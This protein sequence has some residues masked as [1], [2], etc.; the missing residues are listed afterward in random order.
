MQ[1]MRLIKSRSNLLIV[2]LLEIS[3]SVSGCAGENQREFGQLSGEG[4]GC[5][6]YTLK[7]IPS[8]PINLEK[9][10]LFF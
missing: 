8:F 1:P 4:E 7:F 5:G 10:Y 3:E 2:E 9:F 6:K